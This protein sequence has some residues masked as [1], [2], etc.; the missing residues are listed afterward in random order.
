MSRTTCLESAINTE[1]YV[2]LNFQKVRILLRILLSHLKVFCKQNYGFSKII[3]FSLCKFC[4]NSH[5]EFASENV[6]S[7]YAL[8]RTSVSIS[9]WI[10]Y[11]VRIWRN[12]SYICPSSYGCDE[13]ICFSLT[14]CWVCL[15]SRSALSGPQNK[16]NKPVTL[17]SEAETLSW[18][19][20]WILPRHKKILKKILSS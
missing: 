1:T 6:S 11:H 10:L 17:F 7:T 12:F 15:Y 8:R 9:F 5:I 2:F 20:V 14:G 18:Y 4:Y 13:R 16:A 19:T 3:D